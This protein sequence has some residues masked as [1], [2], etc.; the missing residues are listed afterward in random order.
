MGVVRK[1]PARS[2][3][4]N[5]QTGQILRE[6]KGSMGIG[7]ATVTLVAGVCLYFLLKKIGRDADKNDDARYFDNT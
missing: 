4:T 7:I 3:E 5:N 6:A 2:R 1:L